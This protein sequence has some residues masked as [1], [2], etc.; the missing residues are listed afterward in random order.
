MFNPENPP[1]L[2][3]EA[4]LNTS[5]PLTLT[6]LKGR[7]VVLVAFQMLC[8][9]CVSHALPQAKKIAERFNPNEVMVIGLHTVFEHQTVMTIE[10][11]KAFNHEYRWPFPIAVDKAG[12]DAYGL[13]LTMDAYEMRG[14]PTLLLFDRQ[15]R[16]RR[17]YLGQVDD[18]R[19]SAEIMGLAIEDAE[20]PREVSIAIERRLAA[21]LVEPEHQHGPGCGHDHSHGHDHHHDHAHGEGGC[22]GCGCGGGAEGCDGQGGCGGKD[23]DHNHDHAP[24][25]AAAKPAKAKSKK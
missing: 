9:G 10:A 12:D 6:K 21:T 25:R 2:Q 11:L 18:I 4:W 19:I 7:V 23:H 8:P 17:H 14:T 1:E 3:V 5:K 15:G 16:L 24:V 22:G 13:P 20:A